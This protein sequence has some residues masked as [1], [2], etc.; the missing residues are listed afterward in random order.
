MTKLLR[1]REFDRIDFPSEGLDSG[2]EPTS[3]SR[4]ASPRFA[5]ISAFI[6][7]RGSRRTTFAG[8]SASGLDSS[9]RA[10]D[11]QRMNID[12]ETLTA[13]QLKTLIAAAERR[14]DVVS[15]RRPAATVRRE[16]TAVAKEAGYT[17]AELL[18][19]ED[20]EA[21]AAK[22][23]SPARKRG[24]VAPK[25]R[26]PDNKRNTWSGRGRMPRWLAERTKRGRSPA[27][28][29]IPGLAKPTARKGSQIGQKTVFK[30]G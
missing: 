12:V 13:H 24:K 10:P 16:L 19:T 20:A 9:G 30:Q 29:L 3:H 4:W 25:Y 6:L 27:D 8:L 26:D 22:R 18:G 7:S 15:S 23:R 17:I 5:G 1:A 21:P 2:S 28:F 14:K 11:S